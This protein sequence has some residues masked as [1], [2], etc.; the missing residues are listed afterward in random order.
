MLLKINDSFSIQK[1]GTTGKPQLIFVP[2]GPGI[3]YKYLSPIYNSFLTDF[4]IILVDHNSYLQE[5]P[6]EILKNWQKGLQWLTSNT[7]KEKGT[8]PGV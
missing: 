7:K 4:E 6:S 3:N 2:G 8:G 5:D 1:I